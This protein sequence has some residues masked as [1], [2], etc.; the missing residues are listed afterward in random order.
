MRRSGLMIRCGLVWALLAG[1]AAAAGQEPVGTGQVPAATLFDDVMVFDGERLTG[2]VD[3]LT[4]AGRIEA[5]AAALRAP[6]GAEIVDGAGRTLLPGL[7]DAHTHAFGDA[8]REALVFGVTTELDMFTEPGFAAAMR[9]QQEAGNAAERADLFSAGVLA[10]APGG[11]G[12]EYGFAIPT[13]TDVDSAASF[14]AARFA[15]GSDYLKVVYDDGALF[16]LSWPTVSRE[17]MGALIEAAHAHDRLAVVHVSTARA[18]TEALDAGADGLVHLFTDVPPT[19]ELIELARG[20]GA[21][22]VPTMVVLKSIT[23]IG[24]GAPLVDDPRIDPY[25]APAARAGPACSRRPRARRNGCTQSGHVA[26]RGHASR[27]RAAGR[28][29]VVTARRVAGRDV[30]AGKAF[31][32][33]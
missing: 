32:A 31:R 25:L 8:L 24:G 11:H 10:T 19:D 6:A 1:A 28:R 12:T 20:R 3:V 17:L 21:F 9:A 4:R 23:G 16:G 30:A 29:G 13:I 15:E 33:R 26:R 7:I 2:P 18:A 27:A 22:V 5:V 14:V